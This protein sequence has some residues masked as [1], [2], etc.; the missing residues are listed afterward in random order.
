MSTVISVD[1]SE[2]DELRR[3]YLYGADKLAASSPEA[4]ADFDG[5]AFGDSREGMAAAKTYT[6]ARQELGRSSGNLRRLLDRNAEAL[7]EM[8]VMYT[9]IEE[10]N[11]DLAQLTAGVR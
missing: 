9:D 4:F 11:L 2:L 10:R 8:S 6:A 5:T 1:T 7:R 3:R